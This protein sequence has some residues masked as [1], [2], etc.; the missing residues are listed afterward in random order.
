MR[1]PLAL[2]LL[3][4][5]ATT[6]W[7]GETTQA[8]SRAIAARDCVG[9]VRE[10]NQAL[11][12]GSAE[13]MLLG[14][15]MFEQGLC[16]KPNVDRAS[17]LYVRAADAGA[18]GARS[19][20]A[21]L[22]ASPAGGPDKGAAVWWGLQAGLPLP[23]ACTV[24]A[25]LRGNAERFA[26]ELARWPAGMLDACVYVT[27]VLAALDAEFILQPVAANPSGVTI[28]FRPVSGRL[29]VGVSQQSQALTDSSPRVVT[30]NN[31]VGAN[32]VQQSATPEQTRALQLQEERKSLAKSVETLSRDALARFPQ[33]SQVD[34]TWRIQLSIQAARPQ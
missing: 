20:L 30:T 12:G 18:L 6:C 19:R 17:R 32:D 1:K 24:D 14:G 13:A 5:A 16:L 11:A 3:A 4:A 9:A 22:Y 26:Q 29:D 27:G 28:D 21:A 7:G 25:S 33:P 2:L 31:V 23:A 10:L 8:V 34:P 15:A